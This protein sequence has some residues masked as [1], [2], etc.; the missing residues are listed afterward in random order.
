VKGRVI[1]PRRLAHYVCEDAV[2]PSLMAPA[3]FPSPQLVERIRE[4]VRPLQGAGGG[5]GEKIFI[6]REKARRRRIVNE[7]ALWKELEGRGFVKVRLEELTWSQQIAAFAAAKIIVAPHGAGLANLVFCEP[8]SRVVECF[9]PAFV[10]GY[11]WRLAAV[12]GL[13]YRPVVGVGEPLGCELKSNRLDMDVNV[14]EVVRA[15]E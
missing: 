15:L 13:D 14:A 8:G 12:R 4:F 7:A 1:T 10:D 11:F 6:S 9:N 2:I 3:G 5:L